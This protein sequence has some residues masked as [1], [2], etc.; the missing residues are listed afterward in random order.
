MIELQ[1]ILL[2][3]FVIWGC[4]G[5][6]SWLPLRLEF[7][8]IPQV[9]LG[10]ALVSVA[11]PVWYFSGLQLFNCLQFLVLLAIVGAGV[12]CFKDIKSILNFF[13]FLAVILVIAAPVWYSD[14]SFLLFQGN[15][16]DTLGYFASAV[17]YQQM[18]VDQVRALQLADFLRNPILEHSVINLKARATIHLIFAT[19]T[20]FQTKDIAFLVYPFISML[21]AINSVAFAHWL[22]AKFK[23]NQIQN[24]LWTLAFAGCLNHQLLQDINAWSHLASLGVMTLV[25]K[26]AVDKVQSGHLGL[27]WPFTILSS[28]LLLLYPEGFFIAWSFIVFLLGLHVYR[29]KTIPPTT[30]AFA[31]SLFLSCVFS[32]VDISGY[33]GFLGV[34]VNVV[35]SISP[36]WHTHFFRILIDGQ[37]TLISLFE[38]PARLVGFYIPM[39][40]DFSGNTVLHLF[41]LF[42]ATVIFGLFVYLL[43]R[44]SKAIKPFFTSNFSFFFYFPLGLLLIKKRWATGKFWLMVFPFWYLT[45]IEYLQ[46]ANRKNIL[47]TLLFFNIGLLA[48]RNFAIYNSKNGVHYSRPYPAHEED[49]ARLKK[50]FDLNNLMS[51]SLFQKC[52]IVYV[53]GTDNWYA[54]F[55]SLAALIHEKPVVVFGDIKGHFGVGSLIGSNPRPTEDFQNCLLEPS[56]RPE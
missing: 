45:L 10:L 24:I 1:F 12:A 47:K 53:D 50:D 6:F 22:T 27:H 41:N 2:S 36:S 7:H 13:V 34:Q 44:K 49:H 16:W 5:I 20:N 23:Y 43:K 14:L 37:K 9:V 33:L 30:K 52:E 46:T 35:S 32:L 29:T 4:G 25:L 8:R 39:A 54:T 11:V 40:K 51:G 26:M 48:W 56:L 38:L 17:G 3:A 31:I 42:M 55:V 18:T 15:H 21:I 28:S 19:L